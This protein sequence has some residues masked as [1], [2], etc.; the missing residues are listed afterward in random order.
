MPSNLLSEGNPNERTAGVF[1]GKYDVVKD[2][3][4]V[5]FLDHL[6]TNGIPAVY[7]EILESVV[8]GGAQNFQNE[9]W[10]GGEIAK[11]LATQQYMR[12]S[13]KRIAGAIGDLTAVL[14]VGGKL[15]SEQYD[16][17]AIS[18]SLTFLG[19]MAGSESGG[20][21]LKTVGITS[22]AYVTAAIIAFQ[23]WRESEKALAAETKSSQLE[24]L[25]G[26]VEGMVRDKSR[27]TLGQGD[28]F[29]P[30]SENIE[31]IWKRVLN[32][33]TFREL[34][35]VYV[36]EQLNREF[37]EPGFFDSIGTYAS[38]S[39]SLMSA[40]ESL[41]KKAKEEL[42]KEYSTV[43]GYIA[44]LVSWLNRAGKVREQQVIARQELHKLADRIKQ[45]SS[46]SMEQAI[47]KMDTAVTMLGV[48][49]VYLK[50][51]MQR[52]EKA[53]KEKDA[54]ELQHHMSMIS[55]YVKDVIAWIPD[56]GPFADRRNVVF[57]DLKKAYAKAEGGLNILIGEIRAR[58]EKPKPP[59]TTEPVQE[60]LPKID[61]VDLYK[62]HFGE[63]LKPFDWGGVGEVSVIKEYYLKMLETGQFIHPL[64][65]HNR[66]LPAGRESIAEKIEKAWSIEEYSVAA[67]SGSREPDEK[68][69]IRGYKEYLRKKLY[70]VKT[71]EDIL[72]LN[73]EVSA[74]S[75]EITDIYKRGNNLYWGKTEEG[76]KV[77]GETEEQKKARKSRGESLMEQSRQMGIDLKPARDR[78][79]A[80]N[81]AWGQAK[82]MANESASR[83]ILLAELTRNETTDWMTQTKAF[84]VN[85]LNPVFE[86]YVNL[87]ARIKGFEAPY[88]MLEGARI[89]ESIET[90]EKIISENSYAGLLG[91]K[92]PESTR[93]YSDVVNGIYRITN[94]L[95]SRVEK[96]KSANNAL[97]KNIQT[98]ET[99]EDLAK[100][101][102]ELISEA[103]VSASEINR[104]IDPSF[105]YNDGIYIK[106]KSMFNGMDKV[107]SRHRKK[108]ISL[109]KQCVQYI[110]NG[111]EDISWLN[112]AMRNLDRFRQAARQAG[113]LS[114][115]E[116]LRFYA[117]TDTNLVDGPRTTVNE[118][119]MRYLTETERDS[120]VN[121]LKNIIDTTNLGAFLK[122]V[123][124]W[125]DQEMSRYLGELSGLQ[126]V[127][128]ENFFTGYV[129]DEKIH[130]V[131]RS[132]MSQAAAIIEKLVPGDRSFDEKWS[133]IKKLIPVGMQYK[134]ASDRFADLK[135]PE[136][137]PLAKEFKALRER[138]IELY[139]KHLV[140]SE[141]NQKNEAIK[142]ANQ[143]IS[144]WA[145]LT[146]P[147]K[148]RIKTG[149]ELVKK[150]ADIQK[151]G[152]GELESL[153]R[154][155]ESLSGSLNSD[156]LN[157]FS[158]A[159]YHLYTANMDKN[160]YAQDI[161]FINDGMRRLPEQLS[162][163]LSAVKKR[164]LNYDDNT[165]AVKGFYEEFKHAYEDKNDSG[166]MSFLS[167][168]WEAG[169]GTTLYDVEEYFRNMFTVFD[170]IRLEL[171]NMKVEKG[172]SGTY[173]VSYELLITGRIFSENITHKEK[174]S[175]FEEVSV[176]SDN[177]MK[178]T[179]T[180][181]G[182]FWYVN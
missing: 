138:L 156:P 135:V 66:P 152:R 44:G 27:K 14:D 98:V 129:Q 34:F 7:G 167:D 153:S 8:A 6:A 4:S 120:A 75:S 85:G 10:K 15:Y 102:E 76:E 87:Q 143:A 178:I 141:E 150:A 110:E 126:V 89:E 165:E 148:K 88:N 125:L 68:D 124:P 11:Q 162:N 140:A 173:R 161:R 3:H 82:E 51:C 94:P 31:L 1:A 93:M 171:T 127:Q 64:D 177:K 170:E 100:Q 55:G 13:L 137:A 28:P 9:A 62:A 160:Q 109:E 19:K 12:D 182:R 45:S 90:L 154:A 117:N 145:S 18:A 151:L 59:E 63:I 136:N 20:A 115:V 169:D 179:R 81:N 21:I 121:T 37:P 99:M 77:S 122:G 16:E 57:S 130:V 163:A 131:L 65:N 175:V 155:I 91:T 101:W 33:S 107:A 84:F 123:A 47:A 118:P 86:Q 48:V 61:P 158:D 128:E 157:E 26:R 30:T 116:S 52:I 92:I 56:R 22:T 80:L 60:D 54:Q 172:G 41:E 96:L 114:D 74:R 164:L 103:S 67:G 36:T 113:V 149:D 95:Y 166:L 112:S 40:S 69:T 176:S 35:R 25:Y 73:K 70:D 58:L 78:L 32:D 133:E 71:P 50:D 132:K 23:V 144:R 105:L 42:Q 83:I 43:K 142:L 146:D 38:S 181:E 139:N 17:A 174:S 97:Y 39:I 29:P 119:Y 53:E 79:Q 180:P 108:L 111:Q 104:F 147:L 46:L 134:S 2:S 24:S 106:I 159:S 49:E 72:S 5:P 168:Q